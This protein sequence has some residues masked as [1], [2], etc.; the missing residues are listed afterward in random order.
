M[1][2]VIIKQYLST[3]LDDCPGKLSKASCDSVHDS[4]VLDNLVNQIPG[5]SH[6]LLSLRCQ[7]YLV[8]TFAECN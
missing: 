3:F 7:L 5:R 2:Y 8:L 6:L 4:V 1:I